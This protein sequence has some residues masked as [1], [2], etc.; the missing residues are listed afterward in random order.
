MA[1][2]K[3]RPIGAGVRVAFAMEG[4]DPKLVQAVRNGTYAVDPRAVAEAMLRRGGEPDLRGVLEAL[5]GDRRAGG[6]AE[7]DAGTGADG[8]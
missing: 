8:A 3:P 5:E 1:A 6:V 7:H 4:V 2:V